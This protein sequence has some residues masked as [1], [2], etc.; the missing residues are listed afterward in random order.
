M[1]VLIAYGIGALGPL[2]RKVCR[3]LEVIL[4]IGAHRTGTT[5]FQQTLQQNRRNLMK[6]GL[7]FWGPRKT[8]QGKFTGL[9]RPWDA[10]DGET[11]RLIARNIG[12]IRIDL[13]RLSQKGRAALLVSDEN[14][15]GSIRANLRSFCLYR[16]L[17]QKL[18][19]FA[20]AF[21]PAV[22]RVGI[23]IRPYDTFWA[24][25]LAYA[26]PQGHAAPDDA[27]LDRLVDQPRSWRQVISEVATAFDNTNVTVWEFDRLVGRPSQQF[28]LLTEGRHGLWLPPSDTHANA[29]AGRATL[30]QV[31]LDRGDLPAAERIKA[32]DG[33]YMPFDNGQRAALQ[34]QYT[35]DLEWLRSVSG[36][37]VNFV[38]SAEEA[39]PFG[40]EVLKRGLG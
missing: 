1:F 39:L 6:N 13:E 27:R 10:D 26:I 7:E 15:M 5:S 36:K 32:G 28:R 23:A 37:T 12:V 11:E 38:E 8:R 3:Y 33:R 22:S 9:T 34:E 40:R 16:G 35:A 30:R 31:L 18:A 19:R 4:H 25:S 20:D 2:G 14:M 21:G 29:S 17:R 24:S